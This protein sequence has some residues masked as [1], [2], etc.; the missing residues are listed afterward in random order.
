MPQSIPS[1]DTGVSRV[2]M[3]PQAILQFYSLSHSSSCSLDA[4]PLVVVT[5]STNTKRTSQLDKIH[6]S[7]TTLADSPQSLQHVVTNSKAVYGYRNTTH[8]GIASPR[9]PTPQ[10]HNLTN[11]KSLS[12]K[13]VN[14]MYSENL[15]KPWKSKKWVPAGYTARN[16]HDIEY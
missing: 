1:S 7:G 16:T 3:R 5:L 8:L 10:P 13:K 12:L 4:K 9:R 15:V 6:L 14:A 11:T 2:N